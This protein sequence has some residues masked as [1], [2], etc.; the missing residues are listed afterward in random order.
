[1]LQAA[2]LPLDHDLSNSLYPI[3]KVAASVVIRFATFG[4]PFY[5]PI[6]P[7]VILSCSRV[8]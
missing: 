2:F 1:M 7:A 4:P 8:L 3:D 5:L 6:A